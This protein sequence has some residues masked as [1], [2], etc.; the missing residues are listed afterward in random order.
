MSKAKTRLIKANKIKTKWVSGKGE[1]E[2]NQN[3]GDFFSH[4]VKKFGK[5][6]LLREMS[7]FYFF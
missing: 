2:T 3:C 5:I 6:A 4:T 7:Y 1:R